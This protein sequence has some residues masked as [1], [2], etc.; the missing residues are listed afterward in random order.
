[1]TAAAAAPAYI[2]VGR[3]ASPFTRRVAI[4]MT[5]MGVSPLRERLSPLTHPEKI[6]PWNPVGRVPVLVLPE[7]ERLVD[8]T[9]I[10]DHLLED[11]DPQGHLLP[12]S[13]AARRQTLQRT[14]HA[15]T[16]MEKT[17]LAAYEQIKRPKAL[18]HP[19]VRDGYVAQTRT[20]LSLLEDSYHAAGISG[21]EDGFCDIA[22]ISTA[23]AVSFISRFQPEIMEGQTLTVLSALCA[24]CEALPAFADNQPESP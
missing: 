24:A 7:G 17:I 10:L 2:L 9:M 6:L 15:L 21:P 22:M 4:A 16:A 8:S 23:V 3:N 5:L 12:K 20:A 11:H 18:W 14:A 13:G 19:P 1:M